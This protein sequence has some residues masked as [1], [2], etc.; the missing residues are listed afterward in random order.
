[1]KRTEQSR[2]QVMMHTSSLPPEQ[3]S[4]LRSIVKQ[5]ASTQQQGKQNQNE[6]LWDQAKE[7][8]QQRLQQPAQQRQQNSQRQHQHERDHTPTPPPN[9]LAFLS[10]SRTTLTNG[11]EQS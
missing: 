9:M 1:M 3:Q 4:A 5:H 2:H 8:L 7:E 6:Q 11:L 10:G